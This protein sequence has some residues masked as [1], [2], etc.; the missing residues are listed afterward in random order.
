MERCTW[1]LWHEGE[2]YVERC[3]WHLWHEG[4]IYVAMARLAH[5]YPHLQPSARQCACACQWLQAHRVGEQRDAGMPAHLPVKLHAAATQLLG[6]RGNAAGVQVLAS[7]S[8]SSGVCC[9]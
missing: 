2:M 4:E 3:T 1:H 9:T 8:S 6:L 7:V 5:P